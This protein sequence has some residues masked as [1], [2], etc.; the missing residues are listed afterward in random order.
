VV[1]R[2]LE[3]EQRQGAIAG[4]ARVRDGPVEVAGR[5]GLDEVVRQRGEV[6]LRTGGVER[7]QRLPDLT[8]KTDPPRSG[9]AA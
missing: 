7:L 4:P 2:L 6:G 8:V 9:E 5:G 1:G 3:G